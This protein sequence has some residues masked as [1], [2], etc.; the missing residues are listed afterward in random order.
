M[1][2]VLLFLGAGASKPFG[3]PTM[4]EFVEHIGKE[5]NEKQ[6]DLAAPF[7][8]IQK[9]LGQVYGD[10]LD[11][12]RLLDVVHDLATGRPSL[13]VFREFAPNAA[14]RISRLFAFDDSALNSLEKVDQEVAK[15]RDAMRDLEKFILG[16]IEWACRGVDYERAVSTYRTFIN[17]FTQIRFTDG[18]GHALGQSPRTPTAFQFIDVVTT[19]YDLCFERFAAASERGWNAGFTHSAV[20]HEESFSSPPM[21]RQ[22]GAYPLLKLHGSIDWWR[23]S[24]NRV[25]RRSEGAVGQSLGDG[26]KIERMEIR[27]PVGSKDLFGDPYFRLYNR[28]AE[29]LAASSIWVFIGYSFGDPSVRALVTEAFRPKHR[30]VLVDPHATAH[31]RGPLSGLKGGKILPVEALFPSDSIIDSIRNNCTGNH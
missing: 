6:P 2:E 15:N 31:L 9:S 19:N 1:A 22:E 24:S 13:D 8:D 26:S 18:L 3:V 10:S 7:E 29:F 16:C 20:D 23:S 12:E 11:L 14:I 17:K 30:L 4:R 25:I 21:S 28:F 27:F 5:I